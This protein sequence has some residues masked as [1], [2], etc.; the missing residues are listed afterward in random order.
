MRGAAFSL[1]TFTDANDAKEI[2]LEMKFAVAD[3]SEQ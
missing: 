3:L 1:H 2:V